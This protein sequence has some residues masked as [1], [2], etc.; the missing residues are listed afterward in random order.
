MNCGG[1][2]YRSGT[3]AAARN[4]TLKPPT[5]RRWHRLRDA[6]IPSLPCG[7]INQRAVQCE[8][9]DFLQDLVVLGRARLMQFDAGAVASAIYNP[10]RSPGIVTPVLVGLS[11][12]IA[13]LASYTALD[14]AGR[15]R[16]TTG[17]TS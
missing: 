9:T 8:A 15:I 3:Q 2:A 16:S 7:M 14:L 6:A 11:V 1:L 17:W 5:Q 10:S 13:V 4:Q 12:L